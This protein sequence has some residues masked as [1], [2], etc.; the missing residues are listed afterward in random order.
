M[1]SF[2]AQTIFF[3]IARLDKW[4]NNN[5]S[6]QE[7]RPC[8]LE[9]PRVGWALIFPPP[10]AASWPNACAT[11]APAGSRCVVEFLAQ[12]GIPGNGSTVRELFG[13][14]NYFVACSFVAIRD[15]S[16]LR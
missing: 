9:I 4:K 13:G 15:S 12:E 10:P 16:P 14:N 7:H 6:E 1:W 3:Q 5:A 2:F 8:P 11:F